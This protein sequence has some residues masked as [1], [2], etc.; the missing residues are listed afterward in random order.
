MRV[1]ILTVTAGN[2]HNACAARM[3]QQ[4]EKLDG[5]VEVKI[6]NILEEYSDRLN[7]WISNAGYNLAVGK[8][9]AVYDAFYHLYEKR[10]PSRRYLCPSQG[11]VLSCIGG[12]Y[13]EILLF[14]PD[15]IYSTQYYGAIAVTDLRLIFDLPATCIASN[16]DYTVAPFWESCVGVDYFTLPTPGLTDRFIRKGFKREQL[17]PVGLPVDGRTL[18]IMDKAKAREILKLD[19]DRFT[20][21]IMFGGGHWHGGYSIFKMLLKALKGRKAQIIMINGKD[22]YC[23]KTVEQGKLPDGIKV[24]NV[25]FTTEIPTYM[26]AADVILNKCGGASTT[27]IINKGV[28]MLVTEKLVAQER[29]NLEYAKSKGV[30]LSFKNAKELKEKLL[31]LMDDPEKRAE[32]TKNTLPLRTDAMRELAEFIL[33]QPPADYG[34]GDAGKIDEKEIKKRVKRALK[35]AD[36]KERRKNGK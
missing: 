13:R 30:A 8:F 21:M 11:A 23:Y 29:C 7:A 32:M 25:G 31:L 1:L 28:P 14:K 22:G 12:L 9:P 16:L 20:V 17:L 2:A 24:L 3:K 15:V 18:E 6:I 4:L 34:D 19:K 5:G 33:K 26:S 27:E 36:K 10:S 35:A